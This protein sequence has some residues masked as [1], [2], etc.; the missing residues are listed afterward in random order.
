MA[1]QNPAPTRDIDD[2]VVGRN[3]EGELPATS[4]YLFAASF[5][6]G[7]KCGKA[8][9]DFLV[10]KSK[11]NNPAACLEQGKVVTECAVNV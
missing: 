11:D 2:E 6:I 7:D 8:N 4:S 3:V 5:F 10:C 1:A 9:D